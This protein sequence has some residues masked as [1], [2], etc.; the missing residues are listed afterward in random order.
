MSWDDPTGVAPT[1]VRPA[2]PKRPV[3][4]GLALLMGIGSI[5]MSFLILGNFAF[6]VV[7]FNWMWDRNGRMGPSW[8]TILFQ[9]AGPGWLTFLIAW[10]GL[11]AGL[12][13]GGYRLVRASRVPDRRASLAASATRFSIWGLVGCGL[14]VALFAWMLAWRWTR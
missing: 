4:S 14:D 2:I 13:Y 5:L 11:A 6:G 8:R 3:L 10:V 1:E 12:G 7:Y 9:L